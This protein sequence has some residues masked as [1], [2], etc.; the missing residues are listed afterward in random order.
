MS[1]PHAYIVDDIDAEN[2]RCAECKEPL[3]EGKIAYYLDD[4]GR[5]FCQWCIEGD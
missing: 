3:E 5:V 1:A 2:E 4:D